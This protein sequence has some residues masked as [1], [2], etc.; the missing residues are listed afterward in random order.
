M[1]FVGFVGEGGF[2]DHDRNVVGSLIMIETI[3]DNKM[4]SMKYLAAAIF[5]DDFSLTVAFRS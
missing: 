2:G 5:F 4:V 3:T 1:F